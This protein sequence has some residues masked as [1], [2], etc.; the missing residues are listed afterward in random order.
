LSTFAKSQSPSDSSTPLP[1]GTHFQAPTDSRSSA[2]EKVPGPT[3]TSGFLALSGSRAID[4]NADNAVMRDTGVTIVEGSSS[5]G[6][7]AALAAV[8]VVAI[9]LLTR[10]IRT[11]IGT[12]DEETADDE[13]NDS[14]GNQ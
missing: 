11:M 3:V 5:W 6:Y 7:I 14:E 1:T 4:E 10:D 12:R 9:L 2:N 13:E 8:S